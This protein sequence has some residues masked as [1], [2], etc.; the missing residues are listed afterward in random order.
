MKHTDMK[1]TLLMAA[2][3]LLATT[4]LAQTS[5]EEVCADIDKAGGVYLAYR[6]PTVAPTPAPK[7]YSPFYI[8]HYARHGSRYLISDRDYRWVL[9]ALS[10]ADSAG[11]L[12]PLGKDVLARLT[13]LWPTVEGRGGDLSPVGV[14]QHR[15]IARRMF[16]NHPEVF[17]GQRKVSA[18][19]TI[20][21]R[22][23]MSM[24]AFGD[25]LK[26]LAPQLDISYESSEKYMD[27]L[28]YHTALSNRFTDGNNG[29][30]VG[31]YKRF[32]ASL[33][34]PGRLVGS[35]LGDTAYV[36]RHIDAAS[37]MWGLYWIAVDM[38]DID[39]DIAFYDIFTPD[40]LFDLWQCVNY[41]F[42]VGNA[43]HADGNGIVVANAKNLLRNIIASADEAISD[44][45]IAATLRFGHDGNVI[46]LLAI[47]R[48]GNFNVAVSRPEETYKAWADFKAVPMA[49][50]VQM[51]FYRPTASVMTKRRGTTRRAGEK[52]LA[53]DADDVLVKFMH[54][55][56]EVHIPVA[57]SNFP[58]YKWKD[59]RAF[60]MGILSD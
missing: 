6:E 47:L 23:A 24:A 17:R 51:V 9:D 54:N 52:P 37:L 38:Q 53:Q 60:Y 12:L 42:Y 14:R 7:G 27:Y 35:L 8:S 11:A 1:K 26:G 34:R 56:R 48:I 22:C 44:G 16:E 28:N 13:R 20:V 43:N 41:R 32:E 40:E 36:R 15:G 29:P 30:W 46:P 3:L 55:E 5:R 19:S 4:S 49:A 18:R 10:R 45:G 57:T 50:N 59:V 39:T 25:C 58:Y 2:A 31:E 21:M 33:V